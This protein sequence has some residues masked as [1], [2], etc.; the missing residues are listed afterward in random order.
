[1]IEMLGVLAIIGVL[2]VGG[3]AGYSKAMT[4]FKINKTI[5]Q[6]SQIS[7]NVRTL[8]ASQDSY[9]GL[10][11]TVVQKAKLAPDD[12]FIDGGSGSDMINPFGGSIDIGI[13]RANF[14]NTD[15]DVNYFQIHYDGI[16][17][18]ACIELFTQ[19]WGQSTQ[20]L[21]GITKGVM[22]HAFE[23]GAGY[24]CRG[25]NSFPVSVS[26]AA[27]LCS[28]NDNTLKFVFE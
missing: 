23:C 17:E 18:D 4:K 1:M 3:I 7:A 22:S 19:D 16:P 25:S 13:L 2:S 27:S 26:K 21:V 5:E 20:G 11:D 15:M 10:N 24:D 12:I 28:G 9:E 14:N 8:Y 6:I